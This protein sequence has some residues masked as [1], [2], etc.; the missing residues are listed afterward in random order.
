MDEQ[1]KHDIPAEF[2]KI[3][4]QIGANDQLI[5]GAGGNT[6]IKIDEKLMWV[7]ASGNWLQHA[8]V[9]DVF[10][11]V[12]WRKVNENIANAS[13][14][15]VS[16]TILSI[17]RTDLRPSIETTLHSLMP[18]RVVVHT[19]SI[20]TIVHA[21]QQNFA[22]VIT[23]KL[24]GLKCGFVPYSKPGL[25][26]TLL[27]KSILE[28]QHCDVLIIQNHGLV[29]GGD[30]TSETLD[31]MEEVEN[32]LACEPR[33]ILPPK[34]DVID[35]ACSGTR[36]MAA[37][38]DIIHQLALNSNEYN[39]AFGGSFYPDHVVFLGSAIASVESVE[40]LRSFCSSTTNDPLRPKA[41]ALK[42]FGIAYDKSLSAGGVEMLVALA[43]VVIRA[44]K[45]IAPNF[46]S[47]LQERELVNW[48][49]EKY[50]QT[51]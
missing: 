5:Q 43:N 35:D 22:D 21:I 45:Q 25:P 31:L 11:A 46:L 23:P 1:K 39:L 41:V 38:R 33:E 15:P 6:S 32:R 19:H 49:A 51:L 44:P 34:P 26:L 8:D 18:H 28:K 40:D 4:Q 20:N 12:D 17:G 14:D 13:E 2:I 9:D 30:S 16:G 50:R 3:S 10:V 27:T 48:D 36:F 24:K 7:K 29:V 37:E 47:K 42:G